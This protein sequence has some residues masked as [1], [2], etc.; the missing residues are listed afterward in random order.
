MED[1]FNY[2]SKKPPES[3]W[4]NIEMHLSGNNKRR[5]NPMKRIVVIVGI[6]IIAAAA[7]ILVVS[8]SNNQITVSQDASTAT[9]TYLLGS[10][11]IKRGAETIKAEF[12]SVLYDKDAIIAGKNSEVHILYKQMGVF[13][14][15][16]GSELVLSELGPKLEL[17][18]KKGKFLTALKK[19][20]K[21]ES[22]TVS[23]PT[24]VAG[25][26]GTSFLV[27]A[28]SVKTEIAVLTGTVE[29]QS[30]KKKENI[31]Q[32]KKAVIDKNEFEVAKVDRLIGSELKEIAVIKDV[33][34]YNLKEIKE[35]IK[36]LELIW[37]E[38]SELE[39]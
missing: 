34:D 4:Q 13:K 12:K 26:R 39:K 9:I 25:V 1:L 11:Q 19:L 17:N 21:D 6:V 20:G 2:S 28:D 29:V 15:K 10:A 7:L 37:Q 16:S 18:L 35:S 33:E 30:G 14:V 24:A 23:T 5:E 36:S 8:K 27:N 31:E 3:I 22:F 38:E 32:H